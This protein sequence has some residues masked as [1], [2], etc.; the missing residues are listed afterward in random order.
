LSN[1]NIYTN[2]IV[3]PP[4]TEKAYPT[5]AVPRCDGDQ[6]SPRTPPVFVTGADPNRPAK[7]LQS[8]MV[9]MSFAVAV[10]NEKHAA[11]KYGARTAGFLPYLF[12]ST[13]WFKKP[14]NESKLQHPE[15]FGLHFA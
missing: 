5:M 13:S 3:G 8:R 4:T 10:P 1:P 11:M 12:Q 9:W 15:S 7:N 2:P 14:E 6:I